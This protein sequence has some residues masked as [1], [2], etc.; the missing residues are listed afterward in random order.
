MVGVV[1]LG[2]ASYAKPVAGLPKDVLQKLDGYNV[3]WNTMSST[4]SLESMPLGNGDISVNAWVEKDG[5]LL[6]YIGK[7]DA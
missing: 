4:G 1:L 2:F 3:I 6:M 7:P 5:D